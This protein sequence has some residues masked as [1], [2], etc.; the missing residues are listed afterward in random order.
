MG[1]VLLLKAVNPLI[2]RFYC[3]GLTVGTSTLG[4][5]CNELILF[6]ARYEIRAASSED[7]VVVPQNLYDVTAP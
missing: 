3:V 6:S 2:S 1:V 4:A 7:C 5:R